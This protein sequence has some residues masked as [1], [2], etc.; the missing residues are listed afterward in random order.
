[1]FCLYSEIDQTLENMTIY[2]KNKWST[3]GKLRK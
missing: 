3:E 2:K 1:M